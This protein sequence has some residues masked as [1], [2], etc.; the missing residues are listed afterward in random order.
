MTTPC[1]PDTF[2]KRLLR[3]R[4]RT[5]ARLRQR[6]Y[7]AA[8]AL[9]QLRN[10]VA[11]LALQADL[12]ARAGSQA[13]RT[14]I[15]Q[16]L[17]RRLLQLGRYLEQLEQLERPSAASALSSFNLSDCAR[18]VVQEVLPLAQERGVAVLG[19][20]G[21]AGGGE[22]WAA[23][24][25]SAIREALFNVVLN[26]VEHTPSGKAVRV[27]VGRNLTDQAWVQV[28][29]SGPG[30][31]VESRNRVFMRFFRDQKL[32]NATFRSSQGIGL[33]IASRILRV[34]HGSIEVFQ[35]DA[36]AG[37][38]AGLVLVITLKFRDSPQ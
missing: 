12:L 8:N 37:V 3:S 2:S 25:G 19:P 36:G 13:E 21:T 10:A 16:A 22:V 14:E 17:Q 38:A 30:L 31:S 26:A 34:N 27:R 1:R 4:R 11:T 20:E 33:D 32:C 7:W 6:E 5:R 29:D 18:D 28:A 15:T 24:E 9:H 35:G 23:G